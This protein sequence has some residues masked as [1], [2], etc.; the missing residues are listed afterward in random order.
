MVLGLSVLA[1]LHVA[2]LIAL[3]AVYVLSADRDRRRRAL[4]LIQLLRGK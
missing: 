3:G 1:I 2:G 4:R